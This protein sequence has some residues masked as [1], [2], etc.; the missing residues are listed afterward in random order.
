MKT[1]R[2]ALVLAAVALAATACSPAPSDT[3]GGDGSTDGSTPSSTASQG[4]ITVDRTSRESVAAA[5][6]ESFARGDWD[7]LSTFASRTG[8]RFTPYTHVN[9][10]TDSVFKPAD[11]ATFAN[12]TGRYTWGT[13]EGSGEPIVMT[14]AE[15]VAR[16]VWD[17][18]YRT[19]PEVRWNHE[20]DHGSV[21]DNVQK[22]YP[23]ASVV[24]YHFPGFDEQ[25]GGMDWRSLRLVLAQLDNGE[26]ALYGVIHDEWTP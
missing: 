14:K 13:T 8:V 7:T 12:D 11:I 19:A 20:Q 18:D 16:Y 26:W 22:V 4:P 15:Y 1:P 23:G 5:V 6:L 25:Y 3:A 9:E 17:H 24:E 10:E 21:I 2:L